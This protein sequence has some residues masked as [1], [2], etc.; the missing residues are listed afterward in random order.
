[1]PRRAQRFISALLLSSSPFVISN[2]N[3][4]ISLTSFLTATSIL[5]QI[6][7]A[8]E[9][10]TSSDSTDGSCSNTDTQQG[11]DDEEQTQHE[12]FLHEVPW[13][14]DPASKPVWW[15]YSYGELF[16]YMNCYNILPGYATI[17]EP[18]EY[19]YKVEDHTLDPMQ[20]QNLTGMWDE[21]YTKY[22]AE[23]DLSPSG[24][25]KKVVV[26]PAE[27]GDAGSDKGR[28]I[29]VTEKVTKGTLVINTDSDTI[30]I[31]KDGHTWRKFVATL[32]P[33]TGCNVIEWSWVQEFHLED[34]DDIRNGLTIM[35]AWDESNLLN[36]ADWTDSEEDPNVK[37]GTPPEGW[38]EKEGGEWGPCLFHYYAIKDLEVG[39]EILMAYGE[40]ED[41]ARDWPRMGLPVESGLPEPMF[42]DAQPPKMA[43][44][45][46]S[47]II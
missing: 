2:V 40:F 15:S 21:M 22:K 39:E 5:S 41:F 30:G 1:M 9:T 43:P 11:S 29:F 13:E 45:E 34:K 47:E 38:P 7:L 33:Y 42:E 4:P 37:C 16:D 8:Q 32:P 36:N 28:G 25:S 12:G 10:C 26:V 18:G 3:G 6:A 44:A 19:I 17:F 31:F 27:I 14:G 35:T 24:S 20:I 46:E 23:V